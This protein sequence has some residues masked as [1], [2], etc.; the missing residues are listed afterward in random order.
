MAAK[1]VGRRGDA[2]SWRAYR[3]RFRG[4]IAWNFFAFRKLSAS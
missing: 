4:S 1:F 3:L 2:N